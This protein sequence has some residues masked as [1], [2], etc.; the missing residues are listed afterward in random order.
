M[1]SQLVQ[2]SFFLFN[3]SK[4]IRGQT[5]VFRKFF[6]VE[7]PFLRCFGPLLCNSGPLLLLFCILLYLNV[8]ILFKLINVCQFC[9]LLFSFELFNLQFRTL[10]NAFFPLKFQSQFFCWFTNLFRFLSLLIFIKSSN[11]S[12]KAPLV[13][14][15]PLSHPFNFSPNLFFL[16]SNCLQIETP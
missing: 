9:M 2:L 14:I 10:Q 4:S 6:I 16:H 8:S 7:H 5:M 3:I 11:F 12:I 15:H 1:D 13:S